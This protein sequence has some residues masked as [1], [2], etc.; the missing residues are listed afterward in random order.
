MVL[1]KVFLD[2]HFLKQWMDVIN[3]HTGV[4]NPTSISCLGSP[5]I[6]AKLGVFLVKDFSS[7]EPKAPGEL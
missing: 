3:T 7:P 2:L 1:I 4:I 5:K 6:Y